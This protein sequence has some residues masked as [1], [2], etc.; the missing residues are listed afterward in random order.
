MVEVVGIQI[1]VVITAL[2]AGCISYL[3]L[4]AQ[5]EGKVSEFRQAW[6]DGL[7]SDISQLQGSLE[8]ISG[9]RQIA[10]LRAKHSE[11]HVEGEMVSQF[12]DLIEDEISVFHAAYHRIMLRLNDSEHADV[13]GQLQKSRA[14]LDVKVSL[15]SKTHLREETDKLVGLSRKL[16]KKEWEVVK[17]GEKS[18]KR[19]KWL[20]LGVIFV[21][22]LVL[23]AP[24]ASSWICGSLSN[25]ALV[26]PD[27]TK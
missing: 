11:Q 9:A 13:V 26:D 1:E 24:N 3:S 18:Y 2:L 8:K 10:E 5:K 20:S 6:I 12:Y 14:L 22:L 7:R 16:L 23:I 21:C 27:A 17:A 25:S 19:A 15:M 4:V